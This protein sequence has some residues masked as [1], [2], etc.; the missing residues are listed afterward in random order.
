M[1][2]KEALGLQLQWV[3]PVMGQRE[4]R[5]Y[6]IFERKQRR[7]PVEE[8]K[9][10]GSYGASKRRRWRRQQVEKARQDEGEWRW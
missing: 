10:E 5:V 1:G 2:K 6:G 3:E 9:Q 8:E 4:A 7:E